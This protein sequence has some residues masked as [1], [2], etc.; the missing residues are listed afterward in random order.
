MRAVSSDPKASSDKA[1]REGARGAA[2][3]T[4]AKMWFMATGFLQPLVLTRLLGTDGY[5]LYALAL[6]AVSIVNN[7]V[8]TGS[9]QSMSRAVIQG[10][11]QALRRGLL[12]HAALG[13]LLGGSL[14]LGAGVLGAGVLHD[15]RL[16]GLLRIGAIVVADYSVYAALV[17]A[18]NGR[19]RFATQAALD[20]TFSTMRTALVLGLASTSMRV[21]GAVAGFAV[22]SFVIVGVA[23]FAA[24]RDVFGGDE[25]EETNRS[26]FAE[27]ARAYGGFFAPVLVY[28]LALNLVLQVDG[29][30]F[31]AIASRGG[32]AE[33]EVNS[34]VGIYK[35]VQNFAFLPYQLLLAV[36]F[37]VF[38]VVSRSTLEGDR[39]T[40]RSFVDGAIRFSA[41]ALGAMLS[42]LAGLP[43]GV[44]GLAYKPEYHDGDHALRI[45]SLGQGAF[46]LS[47]IGTTI[48]LA[49]GRTRAATAIMVV[50]LIGVV[51]G[52]VTGVQL[53][54]GGIS[55]LQ[56]I[57]SGTA[58]G[59]GLGVLLVGWYVR[60]E[61]GAFL[62]LPTAGRVALCTAVAAVVAG[63]LPLHGKV[64]TLLAAG[65]TVG[66]YVVLLA[67]T[68]ELGRAE[69]ERV[70]RLTRRGK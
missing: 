7:V 36:T 37:V 44:L 33:A 15:S 12:L 43:R 2:F 39:E 22:A 11:S 66:L 51:V 42:V 21:T 4:L 55:A 67:V 5:G 69:I 63:K 40:T 3:I 56:G 70:K 68:G 24:R 20:I 59:W 48:I 41:M 35:A 13:V 58:A 34:L 61:F 65:V 8:V 38:P 50:T 64:G 17:G 30:L 28:Q 32:M 14:A 54:H 49:A 47:V 53:S 52:D 1:A 18:F 57:A 29:L 6:S 45:L 16:P 60:A 25:R 27:F 19:H 26:P 62:R 31:K 23:F 46:A 9:I 10:G